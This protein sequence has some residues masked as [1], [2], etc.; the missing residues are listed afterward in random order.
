MATATEAGAATSR[1]EIPASRVKLAN[2]TTAPVPSRLSSVMTRAIAPLA[3][4][5]P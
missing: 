2:R 1:G 4:L 5:A 3:Y